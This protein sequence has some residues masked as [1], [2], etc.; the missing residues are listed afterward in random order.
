MDNRDKYSL[1][2]DVECLQNDGKIVLARTIGAKGWAILWYD[3]KGYTVVLTTRLSRSVGP[4]L[5]FDA[6]MLTYFDAIR[7]IV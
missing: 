4:A 1:E 5:A 2:K 3:K 6:A 7:E